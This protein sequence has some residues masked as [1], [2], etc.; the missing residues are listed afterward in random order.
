MRRRPPAAATASWLLILVLAIGLAWLAVAYDT[1]TGAADSSGFALFAVPLAVMA[2]LTG[3]VGLVIR[4]RRPDN[5]IGGLMMVGPILMLSGFVGYAIGAYRAEMVGPGDPIGGLAVAWGSAVVLP[6]IFL[7]YPAVVLLFPD[8]HLPSPR[9]RLALAPVLAGLVGGSLL[10]LVTPTSTGDVLPANPLAIPG[11]TAELNAVA[12]GVST[13]ALVASVQ[14]AVIA[15]IVRFR[16]AV[17]VERQQLKW[18][19]ASV[20]LAGILFPISFLSDLNG[21]IDIASVVAVALIP[22]AIGMAILRYRLYEI[23]RLISRTLAWALVTAILVA[24]FVLLVV[25]LQA[26]LTG[27]TQGQTLAVAASTLVAFALF[28]PVR[29]RVQQA[30]DRRFDRSRYDGERVAATFAKRLRG[31]IDLAG[32]ERDLGVTVASALSP[33]STGIW[34]RGRR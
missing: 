26:V 2:L 25:G 22:S 11:L 29:R 12:I 10:S 24:V 5:R 8:G 28:Q 4:L 31:Q 13:L 23:D 7:T 20:A 34:L 16:R 3:S 18:L 32:V 17:G 6:G 30:V 27:F 33:T 9:W 14:L 21:L 15:V 1:L 19:V